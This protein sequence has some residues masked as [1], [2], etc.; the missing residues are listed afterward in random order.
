MQELK[1]VVHAQASIFITPQVLDIRLAFE[2]SQ[3]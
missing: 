3:L 2:L 1:Y